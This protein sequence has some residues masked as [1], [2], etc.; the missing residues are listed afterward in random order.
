MV[1]SIKICLISIPSYSNFEQGR[2]CSQKN[3][4]NLNIFILKTDV[5]FR[6]FNDAFSESSRFGSFWFLSSPLSS[7]KRSD[8]I[9]IAKL[10]PNLL[11][12]YQLFLC[13]LDEIRLDTYLCI[14]IKFI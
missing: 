9:L 3:V 6:K 10:F 14:C 11:K 1:I 8:M 4:E 12:N 7:A 13:Q 2:F 5:L